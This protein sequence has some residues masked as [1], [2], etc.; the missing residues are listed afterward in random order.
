MRDEGLDMARCGQCKG[1]GATVPAE[2]W[3]GGRWHRARLCVPCATARGSAWVGD[4][5][6]SLLWRA[7]RKRER[8][9]R[10]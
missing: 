3:H 8:K 4:G 5:G 6:S 10:A 1:P 7:P 2:V 9:G